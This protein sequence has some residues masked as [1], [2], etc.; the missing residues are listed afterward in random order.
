[1]GVVIGVDLAW[2]K[3]AQTGLCVVEGGRVLASTVV[4]T[5]DEILAWIGPLS[6]RIDAVAVDA[7]VVVPN[8]AGAR[9][10]ERLITRL[11]G[12]AKAGAHSSNRSMQ[13]FVGGGRAARLA[14]LLDLPIDPEATGPRL[15]EVY[16]HPAIVSL[17]GLTERLPYKGRPRRSFATRRTATLELLDLLESL[18]SFDPPLDVRTGPRWSDLRAAV[19]ASTGPAALERVEDEIDAHVCAYVAMYDQR[20]HRTKSVVVGSLDEGYIVTPMDDDRRTRLLHLAEGDGVEATGPRLLVARATGD[21]LVPETL[22]AGAITAVS[23]SGGGCYGTCPVYRITLS[24]TG[25]A[26]YVGYEFV[27]RV[28]RYRGTVSPDRFDDLVRIILRLGFADFDPE[29][30]PPGT[31]MPTYELVLWSGRWRHRRVVD[32]GSAPPEFWAM[33]ALVDAVGDEADWWPVR[34]RRSPT[35]TGRA[36]PFRYFISRTD[37]L[38][39]TALLRLDANEGL[40]IW[41]SQTMASAMGG[42]EGWLP[43]WLPPVSALINS[44]EFVEI[45][46]REVERLQPLMETSPTLWRV[47]TSWT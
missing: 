47:P 21:G 6:S 17:F 38:Y 44:L 16:P 35:T 28:G 39:A 14:H 30:P 24:R 3:R 1:M 32:G 29:Y 45:G 12:G 42:T 33:A 46:I 27:E 18:G 34:S 4:R 26:T 2:G 7:P 10:C 43:N 40:D 25:R 37:N 31:D 36:A 9:D 19:A 20:W 11:Y 13:E 15:I 5:S 23:L 41:V 22:E 8:A